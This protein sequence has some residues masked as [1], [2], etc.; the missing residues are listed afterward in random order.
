MEQD[1]HI[2]F[3]AKVALELGFD[4]ETAAQ[5]GISLDGVETTADITKELDDKLE[6]SK[7]DM[8]DDITADEM[9]DVDNVGSQDSNLEDKDSQVASEIKVCESDDIMAKIREYI[10]NDSCNLVFAVTQK[11][12]ASAK[13]DEEIAA[14]LKGA[15]VLMASSD[16][17]NEEA[18]VQSNE[19]GLDVHLITQI[20]DDEQIDNISIML[21][22]QEQELAEKFENTV[23]DLFEENEYLDFLGSYVL[24]E[25]TDDDSILNEINANLPDVLICACKT[26]YQEKWLLD[27]RTKMSVK[28]CIA[29]SGE[30]EEFL[31]KK[32]S[33]MG[34]FAKLFGKK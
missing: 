19:E 16:L 20:A 31:Q 7:A 30:K 8:P 24:E 28:L 12:L 32:D 33:T 29:L 4:A 23:H 11:F 15:D 5:F 13:D 17:K 1:N 27:N 34:I 6:N 14:V 26:P 21:M 2:E 22:T 18:H 25:G 10:S 9:I 3:D